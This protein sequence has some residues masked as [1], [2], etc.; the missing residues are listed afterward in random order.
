M[1]GFCNTFWLFSPYFKMS[2]GNLGTWKAF[3]E[4]FLFCMLPFPNRYLSS[5]NCN[6]SKDL[7]AL[8][9]KLVLIWLKQADTR[10]NGY[11][12]GRCKLI[13][14]NWSFWLTERLRKVH[15]PRPSKKIIK[16]PH[17]ILY[18]LTLFTDC[19][20]GHIQKWSLIS[21]TLLVFFLCHLTLASLCQ[22]SDKHSLM[23]L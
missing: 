2:W 22:K 18:Y 1:W 20:L 12:Y 10:E 14:Q 11:L 15:L 6:W 8:K 7:H 3:W 17:K 4:S 13:S 16:I 23:L 19:I 21:V 9:K 5:K